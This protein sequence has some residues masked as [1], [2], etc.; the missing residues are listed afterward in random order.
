MDNFAPLQ[1]MPQQI[2]DALGLFSGHRSAAAAFYKPEPF[3]I[4][5]S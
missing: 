5:R 4:F 3:W 1:Q 2:S